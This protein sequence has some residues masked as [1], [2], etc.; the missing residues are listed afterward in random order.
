M[1]GRGEVVVAATRHGRLLE[2][3]C[4]VVAE[5]LSSQRIR[6]DGF[7]SRYEDTQL[8]VSQTMAFRTKQEG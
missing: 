1:E 4:A 8:N 2:R 6:I 5:S 3:I 7:R